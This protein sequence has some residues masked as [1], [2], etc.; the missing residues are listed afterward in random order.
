MSSAAKSSKPPSWSKNTG[1]PICTSVPASAP[2]AC[3]VRYRPERDDALVQGLLAARNAFCL[4]GV[5]VI[6]LVGRVKRDLG[7]PAQE[8]ASKE[9]A[10]WRKRLSLAFLVLV[11]AAVT[12]AC[13]SSGVPSRANAAPRNAVGAPPARAAKV[14]F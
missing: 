14:G 4:P 7:W 3:A 8:A 1:L 12:P 11:V 9:W 6:S 2:A 10:L 5:R 13:G